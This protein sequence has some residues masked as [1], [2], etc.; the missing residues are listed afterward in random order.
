MW[1]TAWTRETGLL[2]PN[3]MESDKDREIANNGKAW[4]IRGS[5]CLCCAAQSKHTNAC[6]H[7]LL[8]AVPLPPFSGYCRPLSPLANSILK[9]LST[10]TVQKCQN[11]MLCV[12][13]IV[14]ATYNNTFQKYRPTFTFPMPGFCPCCAFWKCLQWKANLTQKG[15]NYQT[16]DCK[17]SHFFYSCKETLVSRVAFLHLGNGSGWGMLTV[18]DSTESVM[19]GN[20]QHRAK[21]D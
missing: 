5:H 18:C 9:C 17:N 15:L 12:L 4:T 8:K 3:E 19:L 11:Y 7:L 21:G 20:R 6:L 13:I 1:D 2:S 16:T 14:G 10:Q